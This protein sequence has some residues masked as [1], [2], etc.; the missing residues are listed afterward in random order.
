MPESKK[1]QKVVEQ[2]RA[3]AKA[4]KEHPTS[5]MKKGSPKWWVPLMVTLAVLGLIIMVVAYVT[6]GAWPIHGLKNGN[7]NLFVGMSFMIAGFLMT[8]GWK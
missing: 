3:A 4:Q 6:N 7:V 1:R 2:K 8:M 5:E